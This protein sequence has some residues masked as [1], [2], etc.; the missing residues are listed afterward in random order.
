[1]S[2]LEERL[3]EERKLDWSKQAS[4]LQTKPPFGF[5]ARSYTLVSVVPPPPSH[6]PW[7]RCG[8]GWPP[9]LPPAPAPARHP[10]PS[11]PP[12]RPT[13]P[14][15]SCRPT[16]PPPPPTAARPNRSLSR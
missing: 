11:P 5:R 15:S 7:T 3:G 16:A 1:M 10:S 8:R 9:S 6:N 14:P 12:P 2:G 4:T 13:A